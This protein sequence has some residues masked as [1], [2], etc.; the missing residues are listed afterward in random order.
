MS[1]AREKLFISSSRDGLTTA[2]RERAAVAIKRRREELNAA[3]KVFGLT[4][5]SIADH[6]LESVTSFFS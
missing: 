5:L 1:I 4:M 3:V 6:P 2:K